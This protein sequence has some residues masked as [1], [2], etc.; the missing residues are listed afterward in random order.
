[1]NIRTVSAIILAPL[2]K[3]T[4][5]R[6]SKSWRH[7]DTALKSFIYE[8]MVDTVTANQRAGLAVLHLDDLVTFKAGR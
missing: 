4:G 1:M 6:F 7:G 2:L 3:A 8:Y 5:Y